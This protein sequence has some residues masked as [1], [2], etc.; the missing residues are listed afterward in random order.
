MLLL[1]RNR[2]CESLATLRTAALQDRATRFGL[3]PLTETVLSE[4]FDSTG[5][6][7][8]LHLC[9]SSLSRVFRALRVVLDGS[10]ASTDALVSI[11]AF[12]C[13]HVPRPEGFD[14]S[15]APGRIQ[16]PSLSR[17]DPGREWRRRSDELG[18]GCGSRGNRNSPGRSVR[19]SERGVLAVARTTGEA[20]ELTRQP[21]GLS[22][23]RFPPICERSLG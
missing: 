21:Q 5:L 8:P 2:R 11:D 13:S 9:G 3:H 4:A 15:K 1:G 18:S 20:R 22:M 23:H 6:K 17:L 19:D 7:C 12:D 16:P 14:R 10:L